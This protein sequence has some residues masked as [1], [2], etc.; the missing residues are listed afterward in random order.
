[1]SI[2]FY[3]YMRFDIDIRYQ[4]VGYPNKMSLKMYFYADE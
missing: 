4:Y 1:M 2:K 3:V